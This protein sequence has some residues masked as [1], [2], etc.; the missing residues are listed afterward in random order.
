[1]HTLKNIKNLQNVADCFS[2]GGGDVFVENV[3]SSVSADYVWPWVSLT[4]VSG[5]TAVIVT[6]IDQI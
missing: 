1:M 3:Q 4:G 6:Y 5:G 2:V